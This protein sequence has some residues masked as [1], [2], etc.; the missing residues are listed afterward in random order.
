M[1]PIVATINDTEFQWFLADRGGARRNLATI[2]KRRWLSPS[3][4]ARERGRSI[5]RR[6]RASATPPTGQAEEAA[7]AYLTNVREPAAE[8]GAEIATPQAP[9]TVDPQAALM[10]PVPRSRSPAA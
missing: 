3:G 1:L 6:H 2:R 7:D 5:R 9:V 10:P 4:E 8:V